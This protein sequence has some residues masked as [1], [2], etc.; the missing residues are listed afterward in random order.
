MAMTPPPPPPRITAQIAAANIEAPLAGQTPRGRRG[1]RAGRAGAPKQSAFDRLRPA[2]VD[3]FVGRCTAGIPIGLHE[4]RSAQ[5]PPSVWHML[6]HEK[7]PSEAEPASRCQ[8][9]FGPGANP[10]HILH[11]KGLQLAAVARRSASDTFAALMAWMRATNEGESFG[12]LSHDMQAFV[13][14]TRMETLIMLTRQALG[15]PETPAGELDTFLRRV[16]LIKKRS[17]N[18]SRVDEKQ[19]SAN[20]RNAYMAQKAGITAMLADA[21][22]KTRDYSGPGGMGGPKG[23]FS[24]HQTLHHRVESRIASARRNRSAK[25][26]RKATGP[27]PGARIVVPRSPPKVRTQSCPPV[28]QAFLPDIDLVSQDS[29]FPPL[30]PVQGP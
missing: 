9:L 25:R 11:A 27:Q 16:R 3:W 13:K 28:I 24:P 23:L 26:K 10:D 8:F 30:P 22:R 6:T 21:A 7:M 17:T 20:V 15:T 4:L 14:N 12:K 18:K 29:L 19:V 1:R 5:T 2:F